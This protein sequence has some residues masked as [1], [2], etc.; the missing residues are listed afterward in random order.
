MPLKPRVPPQAVAATQKE[1]TS[2]FSET[3]KDALADKIAEKIADEVA[4]KIQALEPSPAEAESTADQVGS[5][6]FPL[7]MFQKARV[8]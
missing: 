3:V 7:I 8:P 4:S 5:L 2:I 6:D 1:G